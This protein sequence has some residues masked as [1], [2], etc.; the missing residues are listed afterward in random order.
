MMKKNHFLRIF[1]S[2]VLIVLTGSLLIGLF[3]IQLFKVYFAN[4]EKET[5]QSN[6][7]LI[8]NS[9]VSVQSLNEDIDYNILAKKYSSD[10]RA[11][12]LLV[13]EKGDIIGE[14]A[15]GINS[16]RNMI[17]EDSIIGAKNEQ[18]GS[19]LYYDHTL[20]V[21]ILTVAK[22]INKGT[23]KGYIHLTT[24]LEE[25]KDVNQG[26][27]LYS[28]IGVIFVLISS[29]ILKV[30]FVKDIFIPLQ[31]IIDN[32]KSVREDNLG[33]RINIVSD[34]IIGT[35]VNEYN[36]MLDSVQS[37]IYNLEHRNEEIEYSL[38][39]MDIGIVITDSDNRII[40]VNPA[41]LNIYGS[42]QSENEIV[43]S[44]II[45]LVKDTKINNKI[46]EC[47]EC[48]DKDSIECQTD[49]H[50]T[51]KI[52]FSPVKS[53]FDEIKVTGCL[54]VIYDITH[55]KRLEQISSDFVSNVSHEIKTPLTSIKGFVET[56]KDG[57]IEDVDVAYR[58]LEIIDLECDR[59]HSLIND[60]LQLSEIQNI[61]QDVNRSFN[62]IQDIIRE[63]VVMLENQANSKNIELKLDIDED[64]P[65]ILI[66]KNRI[67]QM[68]INIVGN[69]IKYTNI[70][71]NVSVNASKNEDNLVIS[72]KDNGIGIPE[73]AIGRLFERFYRVDKGRSRAMGGTGLGLSIVKQIVDLY[74]GEI[75]I[76]SKPGNGTE[77]I[78]KIPLKV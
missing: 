42:E 46:K 9:L 74:N 77:F 49:E 12:V 21:Y 18:Y 34:D 39:S 4:S 50:K 15:K 76:K 22:Y 53:K 10:I 16:N 11:N 25:V 75:D 36:I 43:G 45:E 67:K 71:G 54:A 56:L 30:F 78:I 68:V 47:I 65:L 63:V 7:N 44:K 31:K 17:K 57:A 33:A 51:V 62:Y 58:F 5:M 28:L 32:T 6:I 40:F 24:T 52:L 48:G 55:L 3:S 59:L 38:N 41:C 70:N 35:L 29:M 60:I 8:E 64:I 2:Y 66:N 72:V 14:K 19:S 27:V 13:D 26:I 37:R 73:E 61:D 69:A 20:K 1:I 23:F